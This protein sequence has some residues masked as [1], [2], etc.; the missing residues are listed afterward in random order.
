MTVNTSPVKSQADVRTV[1]IFTDEHG[2]QWRAAVNNLG[3]HAGYPVSPMTPLF[4]API[5]PPPRFLEITDIAA[6][7]L[8]TDVNAWLADLETRHGEYETLKQQQ[9]SALFGD[10]AAAAIERADRSLM[11]RIGPPPRPLEQVLAYQQGHPWVLGGDPE[12]P[13]SLA[14][15]FPKPE[16][17]MRKRFLTAAEERLRTAAP[18]AEVAVGAGAVPLPQ[19]PSKR[20]RAPSEWQAFLGDARKRGLSFA[21]ASK[22]YKARKARKAS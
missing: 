20:A 5:Y 2:R 7:T 15:Y 6:G 3:V 9:A 13:E 18:A 14:P 4:T 12:M 21:D 22:E 10:G 8:K 1:R 11:F 19:Q 17:K 16:T